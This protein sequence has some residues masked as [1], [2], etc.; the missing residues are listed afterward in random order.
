MGRFL[1]R[2][3]KPQRPFQARFVPGIRTMAFTFFLL[4]LISLYLYWFRGFYAQGRFLLPVIWP[5]G[6]AFVEGFGIVTGFF[7]LGESMSARV[8]FFLLMIVQIQT[9]F[10]ILIPVFHF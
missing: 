10:T 1:S 2:L 6:Y 5:L 3:G 7:R 9:I 4:F 8:L